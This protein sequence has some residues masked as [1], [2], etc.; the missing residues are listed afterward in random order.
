MWWDGGRE[1]LGVLGGKVQRVV[2]DGNEID[3]K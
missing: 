1:N 2:V 3:E